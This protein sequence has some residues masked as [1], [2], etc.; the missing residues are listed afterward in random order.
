M[1]S[2]KYVHIPKTVALLFSIRYLFFFFLQGLCALV[3]ATATN[4]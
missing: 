1:Y 4:T 3:F 2:C